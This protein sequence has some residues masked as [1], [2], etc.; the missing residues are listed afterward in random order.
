M[1]KIR[2]LLIIFL[3]LFCQRA[4][5][6]ELIQAPAAIQI[7]S[8][9]SDGKYTIPQILQI[10]REQK[11]KVVIITDR[12]LMR[13]EYGLKPFANILKKT[14]ENK[15]IL[16]YG[17]K[18][19]FKEFA[20]IKKN[21][22]DLVVISGV[23]SAPAYY[24]SGDVFN[25][26]LEM[27]DWHKHIISIGLK[28]ARSLEYIPVTGNRAGLALPY[29]WKNL[30]LLWPLLLLTGGIFCSRKRAYNYKDE[31]G[32]PLGPRSKFFRNTGVLL[33]VIAGIFLWENFPFRYY[34]FSLYDQKAGIKPYQNYINYINQHNALSF[35]AHPE[36]KNAEKNG[37]ISIR[38]EEH[39]LS[40]LQSRDYTGFAV[41]YEGFKTVGKVNGIWDSLLKEYCA[42][43][44][45]KPVW[46]IGALSFDATG[47]LEDYFKGLRTVLL[48][49]AL[50]EEEAMKALKTGRMYAVLGGNSSQFVL[51]EFSVMDE[52]ASHKN[53]MGEQLL[54]KGAPVIEIKVN[55]LNGQ[56]QPI[57]IKLIRNGEVIK[58]FE[59]PVPVAINYLDEQAPA[60][61]NFYYRL[62][63]QGPDMVAV[64]NP[65]FVRKV[66]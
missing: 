9:I 24:W 59:S 4:F 26:N 42:G 5:A 21:N 34:R 31:Q 14:V 37:D 47:N 39:T 27:R 7:S 13:W 10:C 55:L 35:W 33:I 41:F 62:E 36:A 40:L 58:M 8:D 32:R 57:K 6:A 18:R 29:S 16:K 23:E 66:K 22:P 49:P 63:I 44:R 52:Q 65:I 30:I 19:Y 46:A 28:D 64:T 25:S 56:A 48:L 51:S 50:N 1:F 38:T 45:K 11:M 12:D 20:E 15:S 53:I 2:I 3:M 17:A 43:V 60:E 61:G 54:S